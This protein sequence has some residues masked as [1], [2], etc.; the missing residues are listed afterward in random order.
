MTR[1]DQRKFHY[2]YKIT[3]NDGSGKYY[4]LLGCS[5]F[6]RETEPETKPMRLRSQLIMF[7]WLS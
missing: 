3:R 6:C 2:I 7:L 4:I 1:A 5:I